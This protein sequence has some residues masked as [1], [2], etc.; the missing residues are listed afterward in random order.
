MVS[1]SVMLADLQF[2]TVHRATHVV[3]MPESDSRMLSWS[4]DE[5]HP[6][7]QAMPVLGVQLLSTTQSPHAG[8]TSVAVTPSYNS[9]LQSSPMDS[10]DV[11]DGGSSASMTALTRTRPSPN[12][13][14]DSPCD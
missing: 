3:T 1:C 5:L 9:T 7:Q 4:A 2:R 11:S 13:V 14:S 12:L 6:S 8:G 10:Y